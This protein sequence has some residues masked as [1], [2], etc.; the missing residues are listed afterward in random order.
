METM[1]L[2]WV[3][4]PSRVRTAENKLV[5]LNLAKQVGLLVPPTIVTND[6]GAVRDF[7]SR[8]RA[9]AKTISGAAIAFEGER[10]V[11][12]TQALEPEDLSLEAAFQVAPLIVQRRIVPKSDVRVTV[13]G[14]ELFATRIVQTG[15]SGSDVDWRASSSTLRY[16]ACEVPSPI[17]ESCRSLLHRCELLY[18]AFDFAVDTKG[19]HYFLEVNPSGQWGWIERATDQPITKALARLLCSAE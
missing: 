7:V 19:R 15:D 6:A 14:D 16:E 1:E 4:R 17:R 12:F 3:N 18:G 11:A 13:V 9:V 8:Q 10:V 2:I 5:Q